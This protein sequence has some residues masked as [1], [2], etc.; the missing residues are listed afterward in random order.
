[1]K[2]TLLALFLMFAVMFCFVACGGLNL[3]I[4]FVVDGQEYA[5][6]QTVGSEAI[7][8]P[9]DP[10]KDG[11]TFVGWFFDKDVWQ[12][13]FTANSML[14]TPLTSDIRVYA[15]FVEEGASGTN[16]L[17]FDS[18]GGTEVAEI[19]VPNGAKPTKPIDP[20]YDGYYFCGWYTYPDYQTEFSF[21]AP[22]TKDTTVYAKW[23]QVGST[24]VADVDLENSLSVEQ[25]VVFVHDK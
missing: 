10:Q 14:D 17:S 18:M 21:D 5:E 4:T 6:I 3:E 11:F 8:M 20:A 2:K 22:L 25:K 16:T 9:K 19:L 1:M 7:T 24:S 13:P 23:A 12:K 15:C